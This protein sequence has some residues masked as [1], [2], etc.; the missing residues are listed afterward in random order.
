MCFG[1]TEYPWDD[2]TAMHAALCEMLGKE[3]PAMPFLPDVP[4]Y[5]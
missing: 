2:R 3:G 5:E 1:K 4:E